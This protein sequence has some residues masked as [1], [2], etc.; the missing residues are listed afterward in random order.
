MNAW[1]YRLTKLLQVF[2]QITTKGCSLHDLR[3]NERDRWLLP[4][5]LGSGFS[6]HLERLPCRKEVERRRRHWKKC[7]IGY[8]GGEHSSL[9]K[10]WRAIEE[11]VIG[12][13]DGTF[14]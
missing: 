13:R 5:S 2:R 8:E 1:Q 11:H 9:W 14:D 7:E 10:P 6:H 3:R 12:L 4:S